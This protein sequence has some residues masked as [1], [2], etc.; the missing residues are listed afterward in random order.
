MPSGWAAIV[1]V[2]QDGNRS[3]T[4]ARQV[5]QSTEVR[6][7]E[8]QIVATVTDITEAVVDVVKP[9]MTRVDSRKKEER[10]EQSCGY[11]MIFHETPCFQKFIGLNQLCS[12]SLLE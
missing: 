12:A 9:G 6:T 4:G 10:S 8:I 3:A 11:V 2:G 7:R 5:S 1:V